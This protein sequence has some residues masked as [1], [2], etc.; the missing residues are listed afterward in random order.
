[1]DSQSMQALIV[2]IGFLLIFYF[3]LIRPQKKK[4]N[5]IKEM[6]NNLHEG[7]EVITIGGIYGKIIRA[8]EDVLTLEVGSTKTRLDV[9]RWAIGSIVKKNESKSKKDSEKDSDK[10]S[11][12]DSEKGTEQDFGKDSEDNNKES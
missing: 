9:T 2:P 1:M 6:R 10:D 11:K 3:F 8:K 12:K 4:D 5:E 7:D